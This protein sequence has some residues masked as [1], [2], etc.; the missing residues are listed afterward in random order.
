MLCKY[1]N[2]FEKRCAYVNYT[3]FYV[4]INSYLILQKQSSLHYKIKN[5]KKKYTPYKQFR[6]CRGRDRMVVGFYNYICNKCLSTLLWV[7]ISIRARCTTLCDKVCQWLTTGRWFSPGALVSSI[8][9]TDLHDIAEI[10]LTVALSTIKQ[11]N[12]QFR[13]WIEK[14]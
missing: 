11:T 14:S 12:V 10:L 2:C 7:R 9:K 4:G 3:L 6:E 13:N 8:N 1:R 5:N